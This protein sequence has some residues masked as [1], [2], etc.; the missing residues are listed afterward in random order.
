MRR[1]IL[2]A[3]LAGVSLAQAQQVSPIP[4]QPVF[5]VQPPQ[6]FLIEREGFFRRLLFGRFQMIAVPQPPKAASR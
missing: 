1:F 2:I 4:V 5:V 3:L 6:V